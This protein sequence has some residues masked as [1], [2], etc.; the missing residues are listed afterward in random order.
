MLHD[1]TLIPPAPP[2]PTRSKG[3]SVTLL[4]LYNP[5][6]PWKFPTILIL[7]L[8][9]KL[10]LLLLLW[11]VLVNSALDLNKSLSSFE[12]KLFGGSCSLSPSE[13]DFISKIL[14]MGFW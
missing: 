7:Y 11:L 14:W 10:S 1:C 12:D 8:P 9:P 4:L 6:H 2:Q 5:L 13:I 3:I